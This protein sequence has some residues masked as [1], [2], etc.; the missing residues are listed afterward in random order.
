M[1]LSFEF[2]SMS[3]KQKN[4]FYGCA[5]LVTSIG[6]LFATL[7]YFEEKGLIPTIQIT[8]DNIEI[9]KT[10]MGYTITAPTSTPVEVLFTEA[11]K[12]AGYHIYYPAFIPSEIQTN[13]GTG[14]HTAAFAQ[15]IG[16]Q[17]TGPSPAQIDMAVFDLGDASATRPWIS[18]VQLKNKQEIL[19]KSLKEKQEILLN[20]NKCIIGID[21]KMDTPYNVFCSEKDGITIWLRSQYFRLDI[22]VKVAESMK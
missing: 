11:T 8:H 1:L 14:M 18:I 15:K 20:G 19:G 6:V 22:L 16:V 3:K 2:Y 4:F 12:K 13:G 9:I 7:I 21:E 17:L 10:F 5:I